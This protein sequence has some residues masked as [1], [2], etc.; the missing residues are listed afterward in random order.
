VENQYATIM[1]EQG[2]PGLLIW[3]AFILWVLTR[4]GAPKGDPW[5]LGRR[6]ARLDCAAFLATGFIGV[7][8]FTSIPQTPLLLLAMGWIS[9]VAAEPDHPVGFHEA[10]SAAPALVETG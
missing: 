2:L 7:G 6:L 4:R 10:D 3:F 8:L 1:L 9:V 5:Y